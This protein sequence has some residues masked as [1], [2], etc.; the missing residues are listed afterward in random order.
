[1][2][3]EAAK[4]AWLTH[5]YLTSRLH[6]D[7]STG[8]FTH[9]GGCLQKKFRGKKA[10]SVNSTGYWFVSLAN[11][12]FRGHW[13]AWFYVYGEWPNGR[14]DHR[15]RVKTDNRIA[16]LRIAT[17]SQ[18][19]ANAGLRVDS[20]TGA[21]GIRR[22]RGAWQARITYEGRD[23][24]LGTYATLELAKAAYGGAAAVLFG[25][26]IPSHVATVALEQISE[27]VH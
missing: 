3:S 10:G 13:L 14:L 5:E 27:E 21:R 8:D 16:N 4:Y 20:T 11:K 26:Y 15:N 17:P 2:D 1:M 19:L 9:I 22:M 6:Y 12:R 24:H 25:E 7:P 23:Y 18:N